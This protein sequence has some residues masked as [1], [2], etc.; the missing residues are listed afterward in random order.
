MPSPQSHGAAR[1]ASEPSRVSSH[2]K[3]TCSDVLSYPLFPG[4]TT[5]VNPFA[6]DHHDSD[7]WDLPFESL[8]TL[9]PDDDEPAAPGKG[10][11]G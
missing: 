6:G 2:L 9:A 4:N 11:A 5:P 1:P 10:V 7:L 8:W 3:H